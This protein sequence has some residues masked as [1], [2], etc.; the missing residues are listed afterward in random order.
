RAGRLA[1]RGRGEPTT[2]AALL[3]LACAW[4]PLTFAGTSIAWL[5]VGIVLLDV[6]GQ[7][8]HVVNQSMILGARPDAHARVVGCYMLFYSA[9]SGL[10]AIASTIAYAHAGWFGVCALGAAV[11]VAASCVWVA[12]LQ[13]R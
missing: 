6:G 12:T 4:L 7:A 11:S 9:G 2:G 3:L 13:R 10:G 5:I 1:D 8:V